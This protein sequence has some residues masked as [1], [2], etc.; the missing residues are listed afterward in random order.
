MR[1]PVSAL[2]RFENADSSLRRGDRYR[3]SLSVLSY[4]ETES[5]TIAGQEVPL[6][7]EPSA[8]LA[9]LLT[10]DP[11]WQRELKGFFQGDLAI[12]RLGLVSLEP[13]RPDASPSCSSMARRRARAV[14]PIC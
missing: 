1:V 10:E 3:A 12:G 6:E 11:P 14:G 5:T 8:A 2:L 7:M 13:H 4:A 9:L